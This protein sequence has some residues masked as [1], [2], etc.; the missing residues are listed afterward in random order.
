MR[1]FIEMKKIR[2]GKRVRQEREGIQGFVS[3]DLL[4]K[5]LCGDTSMCV[6]WQ[7]GPQSSLSPL[8]A[9]RD[10]SKSPGLERLESF[11]LLEAFSL[12]CVTEGM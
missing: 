1:S 8:L 9:T 3:L 11:L 6:Q 7:E 4:V 2:E 5:H 10:R 12:S